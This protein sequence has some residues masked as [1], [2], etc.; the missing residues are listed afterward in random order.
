MSAR[1]PPGVP[2]PPVGLVVLC[3]MLVLVAFGGMA[4]A[5]RVPEAPGS[6]RVTI[7][8]NPIRATRDTLRVATSDRGIFWAI[9]GSSWFWLVGAFV[10]GQMPALAVE[11]GAG[12]SRARRVDRAGHESGGGHTERRGLR[13]HGRGPGRRRGDDVAARLERDG[14]R[15]DGRRT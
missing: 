3:A 14:F 2:L 9:A 7:D 15:I 6:D 12:R 10:L 5:A 13:A 8:R 1:P 4:A 11:L